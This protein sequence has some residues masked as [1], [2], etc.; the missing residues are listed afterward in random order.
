[1]HGWIIALYK[2]NWKMLFVRRDQKF[3]R[4]EMVKMY[5]DGKG[6][7]EKFLRYIAT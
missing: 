1:M 4:T 7:A 2:H 5:A 6:E 3:M